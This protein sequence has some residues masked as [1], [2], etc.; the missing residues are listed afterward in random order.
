M[1]TTDT[2]TQTRGLC[3]RCIFSPKQVQE[4]EYHTLIQWSIL[5]HIRQCFPHIL[6]QAQSFY[7]YF[8]QPQCAL[9]IATFTRKFLEH[10]ESQ[11]TSTILLTMLIKP[12]Q[13]MTCPHVRDD[14]SIV[15]LILCPN[16]HSPYLY[17]SSLVWKFQW[18][19]ENVKKKFMRNN[20]NLIFLL[21]HPTLCSHTF[22]SG[23][24]SFPVQLTLLFL[25]QANTR[26]MRAVVMAGYL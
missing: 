6:D 17:P 2:R 7:E 24:S 4:Y 11:L 20:N 23:S 10:Q 3:G 13:C 25:I 21:S 9:S 15:P 22:S 18:H 1:K 8:S 16:L 26:Y 14:I 5:K 19:F 12:F